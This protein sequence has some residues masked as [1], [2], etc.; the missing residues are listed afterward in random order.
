MHYFYFFNYILLFKQNCENMP[1]PPGGNAGQS[2][3]SGVK[4][5]TTAWVPGWLSVRH[6]IVP[7]AGNVT[8]AKMQINTMCMHEVYV[9][10]MHAC[11]RLC[12]AQPSRGITQ[13]ARDAACAADPRDCS[14]ARPSHGPM[15]HGT[16]RPRHRIVPAD[17]PVPSHCAKQSCYHFVAHV[18]FYIFFQS[19]YITVKMLKIKYI[20]IFVSNTN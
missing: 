20:F 2:V 7:W 11:V 18:Y 13:P 14:A 8:P 12:R 5:W 15:Q 9:R 17:G 10:Y 4:M 16:V 3:W 1:V 6:R 19:M